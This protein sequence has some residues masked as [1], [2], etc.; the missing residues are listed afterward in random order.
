MS[1]SNYEKLFCTPE[2]AARTLLR[3]DSS[4]SNYEVDG[5]E[6]SCVTCP[7]NMNGL[8]YPK[9]RCYAYVNEDYD[10]LLE[11]LMGDA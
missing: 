8:E 9:M 5:I 3:V 6:Q 11:W 1:E 10:A 2:R 4:C 7:L